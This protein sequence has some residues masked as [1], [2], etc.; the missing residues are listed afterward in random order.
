[1]PS[2]HRIG[3]PLRHQLLPGELAHRLQQTE[4]ATESHPAKRRLGVHEDHGLLH[5]SSQEGIDRQGF[6]LAVGVDACGDRLG[7]TQ[8]KRPGECR[9]PLQQRLLWLAEQV[10]GPAD[11]RP[12]VS[13]RKL[14]SKRASSSAGVIVDVRAAASSNASGTPSKRR[15]SSATWW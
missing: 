15:H 14:S 3:R 5:Q 10:G 4:G 9:E 2:D 13:S 7:R 12:P 1:M 8:R 6:V 11:R